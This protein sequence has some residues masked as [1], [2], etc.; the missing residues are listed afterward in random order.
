MRLL[1]PPSPKQQRDERAAARRG[2]CLPP[3]LRRVFLLEQSEQRRLAD[4]QAQAAVDERSRLVAEHEAELAGHAE[5][6]SQAN[7]AIEQ[8]RAALQLALT[9][10]RDATAA[11]VVCKTNHAVAVR[12]CTRIVRE[13]VDGVMV[14]DAIDEL[15][16]IA[17]EIRGKLS[18][19][20][21]P[22]GRTYGRSGN[23]IMEGLSNHSAIEKK[24]KVIADAQGE[25]QKHLDGERWLPHAELENRIAEIRREVDWL[26]VD[27]LSAP[28]FDLPTE[29]RSVFSRL[30]GRG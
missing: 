29:N 20:V 9:R 25:L 5:R 7:A 4:E 24:L 28:P 26:S 16:E 30:F 8:A 14:R 1:S 10:Q 17:S 6:I 11:A 18:T 12:K 21:R 15:A 2:E 27:T 3:E 19:S 22:T 23:P 13:L